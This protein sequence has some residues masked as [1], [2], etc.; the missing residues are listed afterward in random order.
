MVGKE[1]GEGVCVRHLLFRRLLEASEVSEK[2]RQFL[3]WPWLEACKS[4]GFV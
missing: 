3:G 4:R 1:K 2:G